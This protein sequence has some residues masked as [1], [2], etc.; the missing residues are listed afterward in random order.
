[1]S[2]EGER[3]AAKQQQFCQI[4][5]MQASRKNGL[6]TVVIIVTHNSQ[7]VL[8]HCLAALARQTVRP[9]AVAL[10]DSGSADTAYLQPYANQPGI[11]VLLKKNIG[12]SRGNNLGWQ[13]VGQ[14]ADYVL[15][16]NPDAFPAPDSLERA[17][18]ALSANQDVG[19][20][21][22]RLL[23]FDAASGQ[24][25]GLLD[26]TGVL[27]R[28]FGPWY[29]RDQGQPD[30]G[31][32]RQQEDVP[33]LCGAFLLCRNAALKQAALPSGAVFDPDFFLYKEDIELCL[34]LRNNGWRLCYLPDVV[35]HH[36]RG[37]QNNRRQM[38][39]PLR[40]TAARSELLLYRKHPSPYLLWAMAK[41]LLV[42]GLRL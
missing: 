34:R 28:W 35:V 25:T 14:E 26:S 29:D 22:G 24:P 4:S 8:P 36:C 3:A 16:L 5:A 30:S 37:W 12:F 2:G 6:S 13:A 11:T 31:Q 27:R 38:P 23:G 42:R 39:Y 20:V 17:C 15:F 21:G 18:I 33:A 9:D 19:G 1:V 40:L 10:V 7:A 32:R 41:Y